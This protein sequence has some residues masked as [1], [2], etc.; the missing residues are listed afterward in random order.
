[1]NVGYVH[2][3]ETP[4]NSIDRGQLKVNVIDQAT[5]R[6]IK[7]AR[8]EIFYTA[9][10]DTKIEELSTNDNGQTEL[11]LLP[12]PPLEY[13]M[14]PSIEQPYSKYTINVNASGYEPFSVSGS[15]IMSG[16]ISI[17]GT[18]LLRTQDN[19]V[20]DNIVIAGHTL[21]EEYPPKIPEAEIKPVNN[22]G[23]IVLSR[24]VVPGTV[25]VHDGVPTDSTAQDYYLPYGDYIKNVASSEIYSTWPAETIEANVL[26]IMSFTLNRVYTEWYRN[27]GYNFTITSSTAFDHKFIPGRNIYDSISKIVDE[28]F[29]SY[30]SRPNVK[31]PI[32]TQYCDGNRVTCPKWMSQW[33]SK[34][35]GDQ[36]YTSIQILRNYYGDN[37]YINNAEQVSGIP[38]SWPGANLDIGSSGQKVRQLQE[39][40][41]LIGE[42]YNAIPGLKPDGV[43]GERTAEAVRVFQRLFDMPQTGIVDFATWYRISDKYVRLSEIA[44]LK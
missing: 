11:I 34:Y 40:L 10:P 3:L 16:E 33:G 8:V 13:S 36:N 15:E 30:L 25:V 28:V 31:Q 26:A 1:M 5:N 2:T 18:S 37:M 9:D 29:D 39:Q 14:E 42:F 7:N 4:P 27:Q 32:L 12:A 44:E 19:Q 35:L 20:P 22:P 6:P 24:V 41:N 21:Y 23:E 43:Y 38:S 17:Q